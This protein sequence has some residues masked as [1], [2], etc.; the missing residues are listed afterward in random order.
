MGYFISMIRF[1]PDTT[2]NNQGLRVQI[3]RHYSDDV[4]MEII[5][6]TSR[7]IYCIVGLGYEYIHYPIVYMI[8][9]VIYDS[10]MTEQRENEK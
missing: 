6:Y 3:L 4:T 8:V 1:R 10:L 2:D 7:N 9:Y 5:N